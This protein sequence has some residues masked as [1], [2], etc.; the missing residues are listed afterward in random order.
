MRKLALAFVL[1][2]TCVAIQAQPGPVQVSSQ[3][4]NDNSISITGEN[5]S[6]VTYSV[7]LNF[8]TLIGYSS[9]VTQGTFIKL[10]P[11][12][13]QLARLT[14]ERNAGSS[15]FSY[16]YRY[17][18]GQAFHKKPETNVEYLL[19]AMPG[20]KLLTFPV[21]SISQRLG[22][23]TSNDYHAVGFRYGAGDTICAAR[24]G[25]VFEV[26]DDVKVGEKMEQ[27]YRSNRNRISIEH[28]DGT[29]SYYS[30]LAPIKSLVAVGEQVYPGQPIAVFNQTADKYSLLFSVFYL[31][32]KNAQFSD[33]TP[34]GTKYYNTVATVFHTAE[35]GGQV[36]SYGLY[37]ADFPAEL[38]AKELTK[39]EKKKLGL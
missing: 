17:L 10:V 34:A 33:I 22:I 24:A 31:M 30:L 11:G 27:T 18:V 4:N 36:L 28:R 38:V 7:M 1:A 16:S 39:R 9:S 26:I 37:T 3:R 35:T 12:H 29:L 6:V 25:T 15:S 23:D 14:P 32:E 8:S 2:V 19:P 21:N 5:N 13:S 20:K